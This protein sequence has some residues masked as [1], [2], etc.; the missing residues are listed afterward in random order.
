MRLPFLRRGPRPPT[1]RKVYRMPRSSQRP[2]ENPYF[3]RRVQRRMVRVLPL[4]AGGGAA[5]ALGVSAVLG[6][7]LPGLAIGQISVTGH[8]RV[9]REEIDAAIREEYDVRFLGIFPRRNYFLFRSDA[10]RGRLEGHPSIAAADVSKAFPDRLSVRV[11]ERQAEFQVLT[12]EARASVDEEGIA[13]EVFPGE[14]GGRPPSVAPPLGSTSTPLAATSSWKLTDLVRIVQQRATTTYPTLYDTS[15]TPYLSGE[16]IVPPSIL[17]ALRRVSVLLSEAD[18]RLTAIGA[19]YD[20]D[21]RH[22]MHVVTSEGWRVLL[23][24]GLGLE[25]PLEA[26]RAVLTEQLADRSTLEYI[27]VRYQD[28]VYYK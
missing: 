4:L 26:L 12:T 11:I 17:E 16:V 27:D 18:G 10:L 5:L 13:F 19:I 21:R 22:E 24:P 14:G 25:A 3:N 23:D 28:R 15:E 6:L 7:T 2:A 8:D 20:R 1:G 9:S